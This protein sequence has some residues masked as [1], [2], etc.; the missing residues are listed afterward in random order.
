VVRCRP[1]RH[2][3]IVA[4]SLDWALTLL[5]AAGGIAGVLSGGKLAGRLPEPALRSEFAIVIVGVAVYTF[6]RSMT[7]LI[8]A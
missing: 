4:R 7:T 8:S 1:T 5:F 6:G 2:S 3:L